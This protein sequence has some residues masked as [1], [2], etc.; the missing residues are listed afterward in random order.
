[1]G[2]VDLHVKSILRQVVLVSYGTQF[3]CHQLPVE[4]WCDHSILR[5]VRFQFR[6]IVNNELLADDVILWLGRLRGSGAVRLTL[7]FAA[8]LSI[9]LAHAKY[10]DDYAVVAHFVDD[11]QIWTIAKE[12]AAW[13]RNPILSDAEK[14]DVMVCPDATSYAAY[15]DTYWCSEKRA[16][17]LLVPDTDWDSLTAAIASDL[18][19]RIPSSHAPSGPFFVPVAEKA[20]SE[21]L[22]LFPSTKGTL[23]AHQ[24]AATLYWEQGRFAND[25]NPKNEGS[26][27]KNLNDDEAAQADDWGRRLDRWMIDVLLRCANEYR[28]SGAVRL[29]VLNPAQPRTTI[30]RQAAKAVKL[31]NRSSTNGQTAEIRVASIDKWRERIGFVFVIA[32][33]SFFVLALGHIISY[34][35]WLA[36]LIALPWA[37]WNKYKKKP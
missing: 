15:L 25:T 11:Y 8:E 16:G 13:R 12:E 6:D 33:L 37:L 9:D 10:V 30:P 36:V 32:V 4:E 17:K 23:L 26:F 29:Q 24:L 2:R 14:Q 7:H 21:K 3:L 34:F 35:P 1:M 19:I 5:H 31:D 27:Y 28:S 18:D 20:A 22:P